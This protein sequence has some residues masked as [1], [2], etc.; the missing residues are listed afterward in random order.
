M[1]CPQQI[2]I[3]L[4]FRR[5][6]PPQ[7]VL[8]DKSCHKI[9]DSLTMAH[10]HVCRGYDLSLYDIPIVRSVDLIFVT[11]NIYIIQRSADGII[12]GIFGHSGQVLCHILK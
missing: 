12:R 7:Q 8:A 2:V 1:V 11:G 6:L 4:S 5:E 3:A 9:E 10:G